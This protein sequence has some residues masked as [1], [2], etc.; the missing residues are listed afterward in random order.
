VTQSDASSNRLILPVSLRIRE[1]RQRRK[2][3][4]YCNNLYEV[5]RQLGALG[6]GYSGDGGNRLPKSGFILKEN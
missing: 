6:Q 5:G 3:R 1:D 2:W 4:G